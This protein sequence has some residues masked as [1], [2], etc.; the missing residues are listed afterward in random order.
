MEKQQCILC[1]LQLP[2]TANNKNIES[3]AMEKQQ[4]VLSPI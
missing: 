2:D 1:I 4:L 3:V